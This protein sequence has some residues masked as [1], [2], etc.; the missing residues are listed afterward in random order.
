[1]IM[2]RALSYEEN[3]LDKSRLILK[4]GTKTKP[5]QGAIIFVP[6]I[7]FY[8]RIPCRMLNRLLKSG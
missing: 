3:T 4:L 5:L 2:C 8:L 1:M 7:K 6:I